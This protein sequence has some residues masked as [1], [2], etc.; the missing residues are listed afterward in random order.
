MQQWKL[1]DELVEQAET[2]AEQGSQGGELR[3]PEVVRVQMIPLHSLNLHAHFPHVQLHSFTFTPFVGSIMIQLGLRL[4]SKC[5]NDFWFSPTCWIGV[6]TVSFRSNESTRKGSQ[7]G[8]LQGPG[9]VGVQS[10]LFSSLERYLPHTLLNASRDL[11]LQ[12]IRD[13]LL[14]YSP[15]NERTRVQ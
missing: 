9:A 3:G 12:Y 11:K 5:F 15:E 7:G 6:G 1:R 8:E 2:D 10:L 13:I 14:W 4:S